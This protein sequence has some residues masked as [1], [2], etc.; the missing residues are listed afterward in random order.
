MVM[1]RIFAVF[2]FVVWMLY[3]ALI[4]EARKT[5]KVIRKNFSVYIGA[6]TIAVALIYVFL[7]CH[8]IDVQA[9]FYEVFRYQPEPM[10]VTAM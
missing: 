6:G 10:E 1:I 8:I 5:F 4:C 2:L 3:V 9:P 7:I